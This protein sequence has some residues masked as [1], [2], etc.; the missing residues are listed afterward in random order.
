MLKTLGTS[1]DSSAS[2]PVI[3]DLSLL[4]VRSV[5]KAIASDAKQISTALSGL[6]KLSFN[7][8][9]GSKAN[10][11]TLREKPAS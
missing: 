2:D 1:S 9:A 11:C 6:R 5:G 3:H 4:S 10:T 7:D 8:P